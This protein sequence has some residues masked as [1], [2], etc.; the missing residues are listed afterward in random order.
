MVWREPRREE[1]LIPVA[2]EECPAVARELVGEVLGIAD[3]DDL[4]RGVVAET[5][6][7]KRDRGEVRLQMSRRQADDQ[8]ADPALAY[9]RELCRNQPDVPLHRERCAR[10]EAA[11]G[12]LGKAYNIAAQA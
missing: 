3:A 2:G 5:P 4:G 1:A 7:R 6:R 12:S 9:R 11:K 8:P 10:V